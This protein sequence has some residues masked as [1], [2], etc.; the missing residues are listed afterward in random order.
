MSVF[1]VTDNTVLHGDD[2]FLVSLCGR[3]YIPYRSTFV[4][5]TTHPRVDDAAARRR[6]WPCRAGTSRKTLTTPT[7]TAP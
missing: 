4:Q 3:R 2:T 7:T 6:G 5:S 1:V